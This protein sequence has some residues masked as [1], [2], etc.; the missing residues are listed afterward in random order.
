MTLFSVL[1]CRLS[2]ARRTS[3]I[4]P[5]TSLIALL[6]LSFACT[7]NQ[8]LADAYG[9][10]E[11]TEVIISSETGGVVLWVDGEEGATVDAGHLLAQIDTVALDLRRAQ[12]SAQRAATGS[13]RAQIDA[14]E[15]V[16]REQ[17]KVLARER[18]RVASL[19]EG[20]AATE[21]QR[22]EVEG[23]WS[24]LQSQIAALDAQRASVRS[25]LGVVDAQIAQN[26]DQIRRSS[27]RAPASATILNRLVQPGELVAPGKPVFKLADLSVVTM[28]AYVSGDQLPLVSLGQSVTVITDGGDGT[29]AERS[30]TVSWISSRAE[31]TPRN[32][33]TRDDR[34]NFVYAIDIRVENDGLFKIGMPAEVR[35]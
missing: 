23:Q 18:T 25:E 16:Y 11:A 33:Q 31:F 35:F 10:I 1:G 19:V 5:L 22:D 12:L 34:V 32:L 21:K 7:N 2:V 30:G 8:E 27:V 14:Q 15:A 4:A 29:Y 17:A 26:E 20:G 3:R 6:S 9:H 24:V 13:R 28:R